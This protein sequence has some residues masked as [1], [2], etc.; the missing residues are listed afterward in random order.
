MTKEKEVKKITLIGIISWVLG[1]MF[2]LTGLVDIVSSSFVVGISFIIM[3]SVI[4]PPINKM[5]K[6]KM[7]FELSIGIKIAVI[8]IGFFIIGKTMNTYKTNANTNQADSLYNQIEKTQKKIN[9][10]DYVDFSNS[11]KIKLLSEQCE[12]IPTYLEV[13]KD[14]RKIRISKLCWEIL[15]TRIQIEIL[16]QENEH[17]KQKFKDVLKLYLLIQEK[18]IEK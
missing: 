11:E 7:N 5:F 16:T 6:E 1:I 18:I 3:A 15:E 17:E 8:I 4:F 9:N 12:L 2:G 14:R 13:G 10:F